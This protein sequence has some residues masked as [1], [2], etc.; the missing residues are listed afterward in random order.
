MKKLP[1]LILLVTLCVFGCSGTMNQNKSKENL[2][3]TAKQPTLQDNEHIYWVNS[4]KAKCVGVAPRLCLQIQKGDKLNSEGW[5][6][7]YAAISGFEYEPGY[8]YKIVVKEEAIPS[9]Q[10]PADGSSIRYTLIKVL[11]KQLDSK[12]RLH[13]IWALESIES[14]DLSLEGRQKRPQLE[15]NLQKMNIVGNDGCNN[16]TGNIQNIDL[17]KITFGPIATTR[18]ICPDM[19][20]PN[21]F[22]QHINQVQAYS[23]K[24]LKL[25]LYDNQGNELFGFKKID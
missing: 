7:F 24:G 23:I 9:Q 16:F 22:H 10:V 19:S 12:L 14:K 5:E 18:K 21:K 2:D 20:V 4:L 17:E 13:D 6:L 8:I 25:Y 11:E 1:I 3:S 15:I